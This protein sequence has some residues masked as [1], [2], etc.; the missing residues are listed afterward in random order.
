VKVCLPGRRGVKREQKAPVLQAIETCRGK[1]GTTG[2]DLDCVIA[3]F[4]PCRE[5]IYIIVSLATAYWWPSRAL[6]PG[7]SDAAR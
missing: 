2:C 4:L 3:M 6:K 1:S 5:G 7:R